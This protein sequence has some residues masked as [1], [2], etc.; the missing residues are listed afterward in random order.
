MSKKEYLAF[1]NKSINAVISKAINADHKV[2]NLI[3]SIRVA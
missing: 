1:N 3:N 2:T